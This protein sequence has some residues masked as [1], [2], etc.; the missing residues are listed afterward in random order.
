MFIFIFSGSGKYG[1][2]IMRYRQ[3]GDRNFAKHLF[4]GLV[5][6]SGSSIYISVTGRNI[7]N[8]TQTCLCNM[9]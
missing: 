4:H 9:Q 7:L 3:D 1:S 2:D 8:I 6:P 5:I